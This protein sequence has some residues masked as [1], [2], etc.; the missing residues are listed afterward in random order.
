MSVTSTVQSARAL[1]QTQNLA[2]LKKEEQ[3]FE[4]RMPEGM[5]TIKRSAANNPVKRKGNPSI[6]INNSGSV[7][8]AMSEEDLGGYLVV[9]G[10]V[11]GKKRNGQREGDL[12]KRDS[13]EADAEA[14]RAGLESHIAQAAA[15]Y[16]PGNNLTGGESGNSSGQQPDTEAN[17]VAQ[18]FTLCLVKQKH[19]ATLRPEALKALNNDIQDL[20]DKY[21]QHI[22]TDAAAYAAIK[23]STLTTR[24]A[25]EHDA[26]LINTFHDIV[27]DK[28]GLDNLIKQVLAEFKN[29]GLLGA[30]KKVTAAVHHLINLWSTVT[31]PDERLY[32]LLRD[33]RRLQLLASLIMGCREILRRHPDPAPANI[34]QAEHEKN[35]LEELLSSVCN[36]TSS[37]LVSPLS[38]EKMAD[39]LKITDLEERV[40]FFNQLT[41][42]VKST[43][44]N[45]FLPK[46]WQGLTTAL[47]LTSDKATEVAEAA[48]DADFPESSGASPAA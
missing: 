11:G 9:M 27:F 6:A 10:K 45:E 7:A 19:G 31:K 42:M 4:I 8:V 25:R 34:A 21:G 16:L 14:D 2:P 29:D 17:G 38:F 43:L 12:A 23:E 15:R 35:R 37:S 28:P 5:T 22:M 41:R 46:Q 47:L 3:D 24:E 32:M 48:W 39:K 36:N 1:A 13:S 40:T 20:E 26:A 18:Y 30:I 33:N 44:A